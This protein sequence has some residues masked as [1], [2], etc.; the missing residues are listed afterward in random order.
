MTVL[1]SKMRRQLTP[2]EREAFDRDMYRYAKV[3]NC[4]MC[5]VPGA[6]AHF[7]STGCESGGRT[8]CSCDT[9]F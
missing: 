3:A 8:H 6:P 9:C 4:D 7:P 1:E 5:K 2:E